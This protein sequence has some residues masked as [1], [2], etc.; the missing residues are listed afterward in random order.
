MAARHGGSVSLISRVGADNFGALMCHHL[1]DEGLDTKYIRTTP[2]QPTGAA[3]ILIDDAARNAIIGVGGANLCVTEQDV[4]ESEQA[5]RGA[6]I[7]IATL[8][9]P[10]EA[11]LLAFAMARAAGV[12]TIFNP[13]PAFDVSDE[14]L[15]NVDYCIPNETELT[16]LTGRK[17]TTLVEVED[18]AQMLLQRGAKTVI[19]T[20]AERGA[21]IVPPGIAQHVP[22]EKVTAVD[23]S[24]AGDAFIGSLAVLLAENVPV[25]EAVQQANA[26]AA[27]SV[28]QSGTQSSFP[29][30]TP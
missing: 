30:R 22:G 12:T 19:V 6:Q 29:K 13:A 28:T 27:L 9:V 26:V 17:P 16:H 4:R 24:G 11:T 14:L 21:L 1:R 25:L 15:H 2:G 3:A 5:I 8:E 10:L 20:L 23:T 7:M 18:A